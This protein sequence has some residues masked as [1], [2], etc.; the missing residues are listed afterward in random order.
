ME[1]VGILSPSS[2]ARTPTRIEALIKSLPVTGY[3][4]PNLKLNVG[5]EFADGIVAPMS[6]T[7]QSLRIIE[8]GARLPM[9]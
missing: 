5:I 9:S 2:F 4:T 3:H 1:S 7:R 6:T 8:N